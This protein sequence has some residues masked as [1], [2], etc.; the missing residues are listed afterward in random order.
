MLSITKDY[1]SFLSCNLYRIVNDK[2]KMDVHLQD[3]TLWLTE[4]ALSMHFEKK[5]VQ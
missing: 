1:K 2:G 3:E 5:R 4:E